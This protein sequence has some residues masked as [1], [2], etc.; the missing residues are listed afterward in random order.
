M[1]KQTLNRK[2]LEKSFPPLTSWIGRTWQKDFV[3]ACMIAFLV[4]AILSIFPEI[5]RAG[6]EEE[7]GKA[8]DFFKGH[9]LKFIMMISVVISAIVGLVRG[10]I[11]I[12]LIGIGISISLSFMLS[13]IMGDGFIP[14]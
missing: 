7:L 10:N 4:V 14:A 6:L 5:A 1:T 11:G 8:N 13:W 2:T 9:V 12:F 3:K